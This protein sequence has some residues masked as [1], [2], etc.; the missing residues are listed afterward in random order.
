[1]A[2]IR[3]GWK[4]WGNGA[5][6][7]MESSTS[8]RALPAA[9]IAKPTASAAYFSRMRTLP[10]ICLLLLAGCASTAPQYDVVLRHATLYDGRG[11]PAVQGDLA[12]RGD[13]IAA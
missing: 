10:G 6:A 7:W 2:P 13:R 1:M 9:T 12:I 4:I 5:V 8:A 11:G 3:P